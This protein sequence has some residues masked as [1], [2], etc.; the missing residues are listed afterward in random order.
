MLPTVP[1]M[2]QDILLITS[3]VFESVGQNRQAVESSL[4]VD[5]LGEIG[6]G[7][8]DPERVERNGAEW[9][10]AENTAEE[11]QLLVSFRKF[12]LV[13]WFIARRPIG[14][15]YCTLCPPTSV[16]HVHL[17]RCERGETGASRCPSS[18]R[19]MAAC[20]AFIAQWMPNAASNSGDP[21][22]P[23]PFLNSKSRTCHRLQSRLPHGSA[24]GDGLFNCR[25]TFRK[26]LG[27]QNCLMTGWAEKARVILR[28][29]ATANNRSFCWWTY[30]GGFPACPAN[31]CRHS[32]RPRSR[33]F[34]RIAGVNPPAPSPTAP[35][36]PLP[37]APP[38]SSP[39]Q[40][41]PG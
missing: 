5:C 31:G 17:P 37:S 28:Q 22:L 9:K 2:A 15:A 27:S 36:F 29:H 33:A 1:Q 40:G 4:L 23:M 25:L 12:C 32:T 14:L 16:R 7:G 13:P 8:R 38:V 39:P 26:P 21:Q 30:P 11:G 41:H 19:E 10:W 24:D 3:S 34:L 18:S 20:A 35:L 6:D